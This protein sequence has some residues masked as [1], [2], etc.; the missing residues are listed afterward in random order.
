MK[1]SDLSKLLFFLIILINLNNS[2]AEDEIDIWKKK[3]SNDISKKI[4]NKKK[5]IESP[6]IN[7][8]TITTNNI[9]QEQSFPENNDDDS[10]YGI[11]DPDK[12]NFELSM[13]ANTDG[14][15]IQKTISRINKLELSKTAENILL[16]LS[17]IHISE[18]TRPY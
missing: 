14:K 7:K 13:W 17:L 6:L 18:P 3:S 10:L 15:N 8:N 2:Y 11:W 1:L 5:K 12:Y 16:N 4:E 9:I